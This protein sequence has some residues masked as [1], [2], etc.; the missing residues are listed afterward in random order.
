MGWRNQANHREEVTAVKKAL[1]KNNILFLSVK[2]GRGTAWGWLHVK[3]QPQVEILP[4][5]IITN[6]RTE[7]QE[8]IRIIQRVTGR[9]GDYDGRIMVDG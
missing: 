3:L 2:H 5:G 8:I 1:R 4:E 7:D 9:S 6:D